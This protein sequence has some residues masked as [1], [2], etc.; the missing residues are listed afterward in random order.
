MVYM[1]AVVVFPPSKPI[2]EKSAYRQEVVFVWSQTWQQFGA[3]TFWPQAAR[4]QD[5]AVFRPVLFLR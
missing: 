1:V 5:G 2:K 4:V 3:G